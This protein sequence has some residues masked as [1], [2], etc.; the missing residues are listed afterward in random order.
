MIVHTVAKL[1][2]LKKLELYNVT[3]DFSIIRQIR[4]CRPWIDL[5]KFWLQ[6][7]AMECKRDPRM[8]MEGRHGARYIEGRGRP[9]VE[10]EHSS[11]EEIYGN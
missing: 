2:H 8:I 9:Y 6:Y 1:P 4:T 5:G 10:K 7:L 11:E 3:D